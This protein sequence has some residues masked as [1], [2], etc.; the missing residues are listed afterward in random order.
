MIAAKQAWIS[1][2]ILFL[3]ML[4]VVVAAV[5]WQHVTGSNPLHLLADSPDHIIQGC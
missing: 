4:L 3:V 2:L 1:L 5:Y